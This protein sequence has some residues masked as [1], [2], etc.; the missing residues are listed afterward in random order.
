MKS[1]VPSL[2]I[3]FDF[4]IYRLTNYDME[5]KYIFKNGKIIL[6]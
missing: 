6:H 5:H 3:E 1:G 4:K 2:F